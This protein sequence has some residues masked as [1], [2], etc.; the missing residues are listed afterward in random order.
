VPS[1]QDVEEYQN[2]RSTVNEL[3]GRINGRFGTVEFMPIHFMHKSL[4]F[5]ELCALYAVSDVCLVS[6]TRDGM[7]L[8]GSPSIAVEKLMNILKVS[9]EYVACQQA[10][11]GVLILSEFAGAA[12]SLNGSIVVNPWDSQQVADAIHEAVTMDSVKRAENN[13][14]L[15]KYVNKYSAAYWGT[16]FIKEM[17]RIQFGNVD[18]EGQAVSKVKDEE[19]SGSVLKDVIVPATPAI[20]VTAQQT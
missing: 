6:S 18:K 4:A 17:G 12:Q 1:R 16:S 2:L 9:Y 3:V 13:R 7:N 5:D 8:V 15:F 11:Q 14:K 10:R 19:G 20:N